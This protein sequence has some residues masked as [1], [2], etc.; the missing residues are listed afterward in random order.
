MSG[1]ELIIDSNLD[2]HEAMAQNPE[3]CCPNE[4]MHGLGLMAVRYRGFDQKEH[5]GQIVVA[6]AGARSKLSD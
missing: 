1:P 2:P 3:L 6:T 4:I 5:Q